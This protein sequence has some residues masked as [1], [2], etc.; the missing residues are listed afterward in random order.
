M[1]KYVLIIIISLFLISCSKNS[2][3]PTNN[4]QPAN[5]I[6][7]LCDTITST[8]SAYFDFINNRVSHVADTGYDFEIGFNLED[9]TWFSVGYGD[10][11]LGFNWW[12]YIIKIK[13][14]PR[15]YNFPSWYPD[16][17]FNI[18][19]ISGLSYD[20]IDYTNFKVNLLSYDYDFA[21]RIK[22]R[23]YIKLINS[24]TAIIM[25][26]YRQHFI[27]ELGGK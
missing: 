9:C 20:S 18:S 19:D 6:L 4:Y 26:K 8:N 17:L 11:W 13:V 15:I 7:T 12:D 1:N 2:V 3:G 27:E 21:N 25:F 14:T 5:K 24:D 22:L 16:T 10:N 23:T